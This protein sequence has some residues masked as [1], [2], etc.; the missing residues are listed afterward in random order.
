MSRPLITFHL[1]ARIRRAMII[2]WRPLH[3]F[4]AAYSREWLIHQLT[5]SSICPFRGPYIRQLP[6]L[7]RF[8]EQ[9]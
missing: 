4:M 9:Y 6:A 1:V 2:I 7:S 3:A 5:S 8:D